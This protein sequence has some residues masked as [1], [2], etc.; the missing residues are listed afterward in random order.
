MRPMQA[1]FAMAYGR[2][3]PSAFVDARVHTRRGRY[4]LCLRSMLAYARVHTRRECYTLD[5]ARI[6]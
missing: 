4:T 5:Y 1:C 3:Y 2:P 6:F